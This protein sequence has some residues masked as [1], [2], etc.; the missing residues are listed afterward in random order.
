MPLFFP[1]LNK[2]PFVKEEGCVTISSDDSGDFEGESKK[3]FMEEKKQAPKNGKIEQKMN[4]GKL[5][6]KRKVY[7]E[8]DD[9]NFDFDGHLWNMFLK[10]HT[11]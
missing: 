3:T 8:G 2:S 6:K 4:Y 9:A 1:Y 11:H 10:S 5:S 7:F